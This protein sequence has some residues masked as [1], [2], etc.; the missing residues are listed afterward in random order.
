[1]PAQTFVRKPLGVDPDMAHP[2]G[3]DIRSFLETSNERLRL[4]P[5]WAG[6]PAC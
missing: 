4:N 5:T 3:G 6:Y 2:V 1:M